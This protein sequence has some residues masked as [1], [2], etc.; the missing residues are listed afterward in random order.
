MCGIAAIF[1]YGLNAAPADAGEL[2]AVHTAMRARGPDDEGTWSSTDGKVGLA[3]R[4]LAVIDLSPGGHQ[5]M[6]S[7]DG[8]CV[9]TYNGEIYNFQALRRQLEQQGRRFR[10]Q[11]DTEVLLHLY[12]RDGAD[13]VR[14]LRGMYAFALWD[15]RKGGMLLARD[16][17]GIKPLY[18]A[19]DGATLRVASQV[20]ALRAGGRAGV[21][22]SA[23][24][25]VGFFLWGHVPEPFTLYR[26]IRAL[27]AGSTLW[28]DANGTTSPRRFWHVRDVL[29]AAHPKPLADGELRALLADSVRHHF[30]ADTPVGLFLSAGLDS[31]TLAAFA[32]EERGTD[33]RTV[34]LGF[35]VHD[36]RTPDETPLAERW[37]Q[38][39]GVRHETRRVTRADFGT[40]HDALFAAMDQPTINGI[41]TYFV[42]RAAKDAGL[43]VALSGLGGDELFGGYPSFRQVPQAVRALAP[44]RAVPALGAAFRAVSAPFLRHATSPKYAG[45]F[46]YGGSYAGAYLLRRG[47]FMP[48]ELPNILDGEMVRE[49]WRM[50]A[51]LAALDDTV[52]GLSTPRLKVTAL[53]TCW[54]MRNQLLRDAD[55][56]GMAH[57]LEIR[58]PFVD[59][60]LFE[61]LAP[62]LASTHAPTKRDMATAAPRPLPAEIRARPKTGFVV[63][64]RA[65]LQREHGGAGERGLRSWARHVYGAMA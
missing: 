38:A 8:A 22:V 27:P 42:A 25:H 35:D 9:L 50:L 23:A 29:A 13:M 10:S 3:H 15:A 64:V 46:E 58:V 7:A 11:S 39:L 12:E 17:L 26:D 6:A 44:F 65:W 41:N 32:A 45:L 31:A 53:E 19:D 5:P 57:S 34:T 56:A 55:W 18:Y 52:A 61:R 28:A 54:Y 51:P 40:A 2:S 60:A 1:S 43:K 47:L 63:P 59:S 4:R 16:P 37:A 49:G 20:K 62:V 30:V 21:G 33:L 48:W 14:H 24:G 36:G